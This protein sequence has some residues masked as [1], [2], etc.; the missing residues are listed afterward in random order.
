MFGAK[1]QWIETKDD[2]AR[3][4][5]LNAKQKADILA[6]IKQN[7][8][9]FDGLLG[10]IFTIEY[11]LTLNPIPNQCMRVHIP[12]YAYICPH[13]NNELDHIVKLGD[14]LH[15]QEIEWASLSFRYS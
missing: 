15:Q 7:N 11:I 9:L 4:Q 12:C 5:H 6:L 13:S 1:Y 2:V 3:Q 10:C 14:L 8:K